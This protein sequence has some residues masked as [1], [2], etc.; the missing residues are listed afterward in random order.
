MDQIEVFKGSQSTI[1]G[2]NSIGGFISINSNNPTEK[3][4]AKLNYSMGSDGYYNVG[5][6]FNLNLFKKF[7]LRISSSK[8]YDNGFR[9]NIFHGSKLLW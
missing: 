2:A 4:E 8:N 6:I 5:A 9:E 3:L 1:F 7:R